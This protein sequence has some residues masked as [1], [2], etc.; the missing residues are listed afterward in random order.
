[1][2]APDAASSQVRMDATSIVPTRL[3]LATDMAKLGDR[4]SSDRIAMQA[5][6]L[7]ALSPR[8][9]AAERRLQTLEVRRER[10][11]RRTVLSPL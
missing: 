5:H 7:V 10:Q 3:S 6:K 9:A 4:A 1:M 8:I 2:L 11:A